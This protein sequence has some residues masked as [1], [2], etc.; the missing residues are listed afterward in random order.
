MNISDNPLPSLEIAA[1]IYWIKIVNRQYLF[2]IV[3]DD[4][5]KTIKDT[6]VVENKNRLTPFDFCWIETK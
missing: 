3:Y 1:N 5:K 4:L 2:P 6:F